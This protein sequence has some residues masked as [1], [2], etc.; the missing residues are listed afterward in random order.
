MIK[1]SRFL[2]VLVLCTFFLPFFQS[3]CGGPSAEEKAKQKAQ[4]QA[5]SIAK[6]TS[7]MDSLMGLESDTIE[8][9]T[10]FVDTSHIDTSAIGNSPNQ[11]DA[12]NSNNKEE[13][14]S[15]ILTKKYHFLKIF[16]NPEPNVYTG[17]G[18]SMNALPYV[19]QIGTFLSVLFLLISLAGKFLDKSAFKT[20]LFLEVIAALFLY[21]AYILFDI[22]GE[23]LWGYWVAL[24]SILILILFDFYICWQQRKR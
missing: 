15:A 9:E 5:D 14:L 21:H 23:K 11:N 12:D 22:S 3:G 24:T 10:P 18:M 16:L 6:A 4:R 19:F 13:Y 2:H 1:Y 8:I 20:I 17:I 7:E